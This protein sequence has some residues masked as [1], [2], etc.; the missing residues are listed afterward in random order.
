[1]IN[2]IL[3]NSHSFLSFLLNYQQNIKEKK[4]SQ[5]LRCFF[6]VLF[7]TLFLTEISF[8]I[9]YPLLHCYIITRSEYDP[10]EA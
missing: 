7:K 2:S 1:M 3:L 4:Y 10:F 6:L 9:I 5:T 8:L